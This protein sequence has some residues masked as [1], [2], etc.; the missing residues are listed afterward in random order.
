[1]DP[2]NNPDRQ[3]D[4]TLQAMVT[5][6]EER[7][8]HPVFAGMIGA[9]VSQVPA[10]VPL[11]VLDLGCG[12]GVVARAFEARLHPGSALVGADVSQRL[13]DAAVALSPGS[14][15]EWRKVDTGGLPFG[16]SEFDLIAMH[17]LLSHVAGPE[18]LL[19]EAHRVLKQGGTLIVFD[20]DHASTTYGLPEYGRMRA[21]DQKLAEAIATHPDIC[22]QLPRLLKAAGFRLERHRSELFSECGRGDFW[23]SSVRGFARLIPALGILP[24]EEG[25]AWVEAML[26]S[27]ED[28][29]FFAAGSYYT[30]FASKD[31]A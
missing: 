2:Y 11:R 14:R 25:R 17:T 7:G 13:L 12:T 5:R 28:G 18:A 31:P 22:R 9:Y 1:M 29:T 20:A 19:R 6:L 30:F 15:I 3:S 24:E 10:E 23:L 26:G 16:D 4:A 27:H 21:V 8:R